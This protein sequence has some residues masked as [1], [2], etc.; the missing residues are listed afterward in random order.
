[1]NL[2]DLLP[3]N[4]VRRVVLFCLN[5]LGQSLVD[6][7][8]TLYDANKMVAAMNTIIEGRIASPRLPSSASED[9]ELG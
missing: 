4:D 9:T 3:A 5:D 8:H 1:M 6:V 2:I 7:E